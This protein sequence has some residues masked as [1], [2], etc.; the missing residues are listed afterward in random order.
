MVVLRSV[1]PELLLLLSAL[2]VL[3][4]DAF[5]ARYRG[6]IFALTGFALLLAIVL[7]L[8]QWFEPLILV[9]TLAEGWIT[10]D[11]LSIG[12]RI[13]L[14]V[15]MAIVLLYGQQAIVRDMPHAYGEFFALALFCLL[16]M[17]VLVSAAH[18]LTVY[19]G[20]ELFSLALY[21]LI[22]MHRKDERSVEA[23]LKYFVLG[24]LASGILL[25]GISMLYGATGALQLSA[26]HDV[27]VAQNGEGSQ[28]VLMV[29]GMI[30]MMVAV[31]FKLGIF[32]FH[33]WM[34]DVYQGSASVMAL[35]VA[36]VSKCA[37]FGMAFR[38]FHDLFWPVQ[39]FWADVFQILGVAS[40][41]YG[42][43]VAIAQRNVRR[44]LGYSAVG[45][46]GFV[47]L[48][49]SWIATEAGTPLSAGQSVVDPL[50]GFA[51]GLFYVITY[52][53]MGSFVLGLIVLLQ[54]RYGHALATLED[55]RGLSERHPW[56]AFLFL[57]VLLSMAG[58]PPFLGFVAK[59][60][61]LKGLVEQGAWVVAVLVG[62]FSVIGSFYYLR[63][64]WMIYFEKVPVEASV[65]TGSAIVWDGVVWDQQINIKTLGFFPS[66]QWGIVGVHGLLLLFLGLGA[67]VLITWCCRL[68]AAG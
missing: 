5:S 56:I 32:P 31:L 68:V 24:A 62:L 52:G 58:I 37:A 1:L 15:L 34:P 16:G 59:F 30:F 48:A 20:L 42:N 18:L 43:W 47:L 9:N 28:W 63:W 17:M 51:S 22:A 19:L 29:F 35:L 44:M 46:M 10:L 67:Q 65:I 23:A 54:D 27:I 55:Y 40:V 38:I 2:G 25:Y 61:V 64:I 13:V 7:L 11:P 21:A 41:I 3:L 60:W 45:H 26:I 4:L 57:L 50:L 66:L 49:L 53:V 6:S 39:F 33:F 12:L 14:C 8:Q 36:A